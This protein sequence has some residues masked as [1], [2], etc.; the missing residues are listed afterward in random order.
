MIER[1]EGELDREASPVT[2]LID[3]Q[4]IGGKS[5]YGQILTVIDHGNCDYHGQL[6]T[7]MS[8]IPQSINRG[9]LQIPLIPHV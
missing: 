8:A 4:T 1:H 9:L 3:G 2:T 6:P 7:V 5:V